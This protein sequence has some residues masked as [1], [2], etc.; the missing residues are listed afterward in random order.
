MR[1]LCRLDTISLSIGLTGERIFKH[2]RVIAVATVEWVAR[3]VK[4]IGT[5]VDRDAV[6]QKE[7]K[8]LYEI[9]FFK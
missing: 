7:I 6:R 2:A 5:A 4:C 1:F 9:R 3:Y 8:R